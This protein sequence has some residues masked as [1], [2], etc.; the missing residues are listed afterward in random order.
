MLFRSLLAE[1]LCK[2]LDVFEQRS[3]FGGVWNYSTTTKNNKLCVPQT[4]PNQPVEDPTWQTEGR[5]SD[6]G[7]S[8]KIIFPTPMYDGLETNIPDLLMAHSDDQSLMSQQLFPSREMVLIYLEQ[9]ANGIR[10]LVSFN[11]QVMDVRLNEGHGGE[12][13]AVHI[14]NLITQETRVKDFDAV[15]IASGHYDVP[16]IPNIKGI[17]AWNHANPGLVSHSKTYSNPSFYKGKKTVIVGYSASGVDIASQIS[18]TASLP[19][20]VSQRSPSAL[21]FPVSYKTDVPEIIEF[22]PTSKGDR[23]VL[24]ADG[25]VESCIDAVL[26][27]TG[28][29]Y[30]LPF[31][32][33]LAPPLLSTGER[34]QNLYKH[35]FYIE[36]PTLAFV[37][38]PSK[39]IPFRTFEAQATII[40][41]IW[42]GKLTL[43]SKGRM[44]AWE[45]DLLQCRGSG[46]AF[47]TLD[48]PKDFDY[49]DELIGWASSVASG[50]PGRLPSR[51]TEE[52]RWIRKRIP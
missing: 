49:H 35:I 29:F 31:L 4:S 10:D 39:I 42:S 40:A 19:I 50:I 46:K 13:W 12:Y 52:D 34:V 7:H 33:T 1:E 41:R 47:H 22:L 38:L 2:E 5:D 21:T 37:G 43:P 16:L 3:S 44:K 30:T 27:C 9:Y 20:L 45:E 11:A 32:S 24:F 17:G 14:K 48:H 8:E 6:V 23:A 36:H 51:W 28:Y 15:V 18:T 25:H 26:F